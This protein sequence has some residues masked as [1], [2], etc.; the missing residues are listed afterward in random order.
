MSLA[1]GRLKRVVE[2]APTPTAQQDVMPL[3]AQAEAVMQRVRDMARDFGPVSTFAARLNS[4]PDGHNH[5]ARL[6]QALEQHRE[7][8]QRLREIS[9]AIE[10]TNPPLSRALSDIGR[11]EDRVVER[12]RDL[13]ARADPQALN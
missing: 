9:I 6:L 5:W 12:L 1:V 7:V 8:R 10:D 3:V 2:L 11:D 4:E 13:I